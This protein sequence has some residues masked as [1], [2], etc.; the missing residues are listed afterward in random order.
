VRLRVFQRLHVAVDLRRHDARALGDVAADH[1]H[2]AEF[3]DRVRE[4]ED[5]RLHDAR[6]RERQHHL[7]EGGERSGAQRRRG[8][9]RPPA[10]GLERVGQRLHGERQ[11]IEDGPEQQA[12]EGEG[13]QPEAQG[14]RELTA[15]AERAEHHQQVEAQHGGRQHQRQRHQ[16]RDGAAP[17]RVRPRQPPCERRREQQQQHGGGE[18]Q[19]EGQPD[20]LQ[21]AGTEVHGP[22]VA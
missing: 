5:G 11:R 1:Q 15:P 16:R 18:R 4:A 14:L 9:Q 13:Q 19:P 20:R 7:E 2:H 10:D 21:V 12:A 6:A 8:F 17:A 22:Q 3:A